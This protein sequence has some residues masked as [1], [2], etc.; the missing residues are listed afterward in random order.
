MNKKLLSSIIALSITGIVLLTGCDQATPKNI[1]VYEFDTAIVQYELTGTSEGSETLYIKG[2]NK[3]TERFAAQDGAE[4]QTL[5][6]ELGAVKYS[7]NLQNNT[8]IKLD[9]E[10]YEAL[11]NMSK[12]EQEMFLVKNELG[13]AQ[14]AE[15]P[16]K[17]GEAIVAG[18]TCNIYNVSN[19]GTACIWN[20]IVLQKETTLLGVTN[21]KIAT[22]VK[23]NIQIPD[24]RFDLPSGAIIENE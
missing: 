21:S 18:Q 7:V 12:E 24:E 17:I 6:L 22:E 13:L 4:S 8:V 16:Q 3:S 14:S 2:D 20:G 9:N 10:D 1:K 19:I 5:D 15:N 23:T 11:K